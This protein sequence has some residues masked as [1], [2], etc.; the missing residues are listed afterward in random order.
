DSWTVNVADGDQR[1][2]TT[3][4]LVDAYHQGVVTEETFCWKDGMGDWLPMREIEQLASAAGL[5]GAAQSPDQTQEE[6]HQP[7]AGMG[8]GMGMGGGF[9]PPP[10]P[11]APTQQQDQGVFP[12][13]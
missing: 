2:M 5:G 9:D 10:P 4:E 13:Y 11:S 12:G 1:T 8:G 3:Q 6:Q 7:D